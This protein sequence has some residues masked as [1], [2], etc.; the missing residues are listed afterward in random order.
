[1]GA[2]MPNPNPNPNPNQAIVGD[3]SLAFRLMGADMYHGMSRLVLPCARVARGVA[4]HKMSRLLTLALGG[5]AYLTFMGN[6][7]GHPEWVDFP[8][9]GNGNSLDMA[10][11]RWDLADD[12]NLR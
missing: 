1:M 4:L 10:R 6:E 7:F 11:R 2:D 8:R 12:P 9:E 3:Q 5:E